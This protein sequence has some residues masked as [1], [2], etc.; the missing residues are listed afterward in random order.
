MKIE[1]C[2]HCGD[3]HVR[4]FGELDEHNSAFV[5]TTLDTLSDGKE[6]KRLYIDMS[7]LVF[8]DS[9]GVGVLIGRYKRLAPRGIRIFIQSPPPIV[10]KVLCMSGIY[11]IISKAG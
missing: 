7:E 9:T 6:I 5:R 10:D 4:L 2:E 8:M 3:L 1:H 11:D